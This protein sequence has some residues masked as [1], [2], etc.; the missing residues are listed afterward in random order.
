MLADSQVPQFAAFFPFDF[1]CGGLGSFDVK[2]IEV[3]DLISGIVEA[4][5]CHPNF[6]FGLENVRNIDA[7]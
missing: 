2:V 1:A 7:M 3:R 5:E 4:D 6:A